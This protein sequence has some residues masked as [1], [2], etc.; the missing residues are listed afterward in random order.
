MTILEKVYF[1]VGKFLANIVASFITNKEKR[2]RVRY[3]LNPLNP[4]RCVGYMERHYASK[5]ACL[6]SHLLGQASPYIWQCWLQ[7]EEQAPQIVKD[8]IASVRHFKRPNQQHIVI[9]AKNYEQYVSLPSCIIAKWHSGIISNTHF[10]DLLRIHLLHQ[11]GGYW[12]DAT[13]LLTAPIPQ[14]ITEEPL[15]MFHSHGE[16]SYTLIQ[17]CFIHCAAASYTMQRWCEIMDSYWEKENKLIQYFLLHLAF[18]A[19]VKQDRFFREAY[20]RMPKKSDAPAH[21]LQDM[22]RSGDRHTDE[23]LCQVRD[24]GFWQKLTYQTSP[25]TQAK[26]HALCKQI[27]EEP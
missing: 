25:E 15:F 23:L 2:H 12:I 5:P 24:A 26:W 20:E 3:R 16:F 13:C 18:V 9:T 8:C 1:S 27:I 11:Y 17:S 22:A 4:E 6:A 7:G 19:L 10:S 14:E 21:L